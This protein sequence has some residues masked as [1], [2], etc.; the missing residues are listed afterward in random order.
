MVTGISQ[1]H[2]FSLVH[3]ADPR[4]YSFNI[5]NDYILKFFCEM[6]LVTYGYGCKLQIWRR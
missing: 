4:E 5:A 2:I 3:H 6:P 1:M